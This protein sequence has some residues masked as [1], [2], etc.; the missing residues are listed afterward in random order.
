MNTAPL[1]EL[2]D[3][4]AT[5]GAVEAL[6]ASGQSVEF[7]LEQ[8]QRGHWGS[9]SPEDQRA[10]DDAVAAGERILSEYRTL[11]GVQVWVITE[12][13]RNSTCVLLPGEY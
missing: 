13:D 3:C 4:V 2:G 8:H 6:A 12:A 9:V 5:P 7:F 10:N 11:L 1:F